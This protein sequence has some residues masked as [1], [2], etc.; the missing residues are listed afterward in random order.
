MDTFAT[1]R[2]AAVQMIDTSKRM[3]GRPSYYKAII[4]F[5]TG[6]DMKH[7]AG[8]DSWAWSKAEQLLQ[9]A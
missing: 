2:D 7:Y 6:A 9:A 5:S 1:A 8:V 3:K 4:A